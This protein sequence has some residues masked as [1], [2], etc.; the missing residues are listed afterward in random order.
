[1]F[2]LYSWTSCQEAYFGGDGATRSHQLTGGQKQ[3][4]RYNDDGGPGIIC[5]LRCPT[6]MGTSYPNWLRIR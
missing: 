3:G 6:L 4:T 1:M 2:V 5:H